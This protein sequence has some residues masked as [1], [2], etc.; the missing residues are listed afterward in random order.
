[1]EEIQEDEL[2]RYAQAV[3]Y[4]IERPEAPLD[5]VLRAYVNKV[6][7]MVEEQEQKK[8]KGQAVLRSC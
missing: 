6:K 1:M 2:E 3:L 4:F 5:P 8:D 7:K